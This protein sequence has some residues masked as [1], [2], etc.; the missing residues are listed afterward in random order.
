[1][2]VQEPPE[3]SPENTAS[4]GVEVEIPSVE[5]NLTPAKTVQYCGATLCS[6]CARI[7]VKLRA[8]QKSNYGSKKRAAKYVS[9]LREQVTL[10]IIL[11]F[12]KN[13]I[14]ISLR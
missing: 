11:K 6:Q 14:S 12:D 7:K 3:P 9:I 1:M 10:R 5:I 13:L 2:E 8:M 4:Q